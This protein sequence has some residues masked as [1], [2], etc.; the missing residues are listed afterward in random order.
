M[1]EQI[2]INDEAVVVPPEVVTAG[3]A[4]VQAWYDRQLN[5]APAP[6]PEQDAPSTDHSE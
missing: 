1:S 6:T 5:A 2:M 3:R 4:A